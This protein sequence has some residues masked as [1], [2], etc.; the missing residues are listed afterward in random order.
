MAQVNL[1]KLNMY[2]RLWADGSAS[3]AKLNMYARLVPGDGGGDDT[4]NRQGHVYSIRI[5][6]R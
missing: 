4:S 6:A 2:L 3:I 1:A 5:G